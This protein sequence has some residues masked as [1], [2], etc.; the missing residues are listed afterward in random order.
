MTPPVQR[1]HNGSYVE[2]DRAVLDLGPIGLAV[3]D[4]PTRKADPPWQT[5][6]ARVE[7]A[8]AFDMTIR[9]IMRVTAHGPISVYP[10]Q[11]SS[12]VIIG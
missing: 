4:H 1:V 6:A 7:H 2:R 12:D 5:D 8:N 10:R 11:E 3:D 9:W